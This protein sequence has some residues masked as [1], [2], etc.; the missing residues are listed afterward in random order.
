[1]QKDLSNQKIDSLLKREKM[2]RYIEFCDGQLLVEAWGVPYNMMKYCPINKYK[3]S[4]IG[5]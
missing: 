4:G 1:M 2:L 3:K 5:V